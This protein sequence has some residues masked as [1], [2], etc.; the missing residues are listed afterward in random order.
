MSANIE[1]RRFIT[2]LGGATAAWP[3]A[4]R[5]QQPTMPLIGVLSSS[6]ES[7]PQGQKYV[8]AF[9]EGLK[10]LGW[11][12]GRNVRIDYRWGSADPTRIRTYAA[13]LVGLKPDVIFADTSLGVAPLQR[14]TRTIPIVF[15]RI[16]DP[17]ASGFVESLA[18]P[19]GN[20][21]GFTPREFAVAGKWLEMLKEI[22]PGINRVAVIF[23]PDQAP[24]IGM[25]RV[26]E[27]VAPLIGVRLTEAAV[28]DTAEIERSIGAFARESKG[29]LIVVPSPIT[30]RHREQ[31][32]ALA[33]RHRLPAVYGYRYFSTDGGL[34]SY[35]PDLIDQF[36]RA[37]AYVDRILK[38]EKP[39]DLPVQA[40]TKYELVINLKTAKA[41]GLD[42]PP[43]L[44][45]QANE[46]IE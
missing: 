31:I 4:A 36:R 3:L 39:A 28:R 41:L 42:V 33:A 45:A 25:S 8:A 15:T 20:V 1:R 46:V 22:A 38:G 24:Q 21:T 12:D 32:I 29:G 17:V 43:M 30:D 18:R 27:G 16:S 40:P 6:A 44:L 2:L 11:A 37:A 19:G 26:I 9:R 14:E 34:I 23:N 10:E 5:A 7:D 35:G 13:E